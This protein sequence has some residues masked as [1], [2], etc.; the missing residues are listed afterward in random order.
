MLD[1]LIWEYSEYDLPFFSTCARGCFSSFLSRKLQ[2]HHSIGSQEAE[3]NRQKTR[4][5]NLF[6]LSGRC[7]RGSMKRIPH[8]RGYAF[9]TVKGFGRETK[10]GRLKNSREPTRPKKYSAR[11]PTE[12]RVRPAR[13][14]Y[15]N[16]ICAGRT[17]REASLVAGNSAKTWRIEDREQFSRA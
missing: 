9:R 3:S 10:L 6:F 12:I 15:G 4:A 17:S 16:Q 14:W 7:E 11:P 5:A 13:I 1:Q 2:N 8:D